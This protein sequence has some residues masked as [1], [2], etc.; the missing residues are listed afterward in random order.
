MLPGAPVAGG[1]RVAMTS[2][3]TARTDGDDGDD[4]RATRARATTGATDDADDSPAPL[5][6]Y[7]AGDVVFARGV[8]ARGREPM[9]PGV[10]V[11]VGRAPE[12]VRRDFAAACC[13]VMFYGPSGTR[14]RERDYCWAPAEG[15][16]AWARGVRRGLDAQRVAKRMRPRAFEEA[17][18]E[19]REAAAAGEDDV[20]ATESE[21]RADDRGG[22]GKGLDGDDGSREG[23]R[24]DEV[25]V[26]GLQDSFGLPCSAPAERLATRRCASCGV[27]DD[28]SLRSKNSNGLC[29]L[30][31]KLHKEGQFCPVCDRVWHWSAGDAMVGCDRCEMWIHR[32]CD[33]VAAEV[34]DREQNGEDEDIPYAC[35]VCRSKTP[36]QIAAEARLAEQA[37]VEAER[38]A[39]IRERKR[40]EKLLS[41]P[42]VGRPSKE[43]KEAKVLLRRMP[44]LDKLLKGS[45]SASVRAGTMKSPHAVSKKQN[46]VPKRPKSSWQLFAADFFQQYKDENG[47]D[48]IDFAAVYR[49]QGAAWREIDA[50][51]RER[52]EEL[53]R[54]EAERFREMITEMF[55]SGELDD[56]QRKRYD[57]ILNPDA[58]A[59]RVK[60]ERNPDASKA[61]RRSKAGDIS[62][63]RDGNEL[64]ETL[65]V[66]CNG[67][68]ADYYTRLNQ[69]MCQCSDCAGTNKYMTPTEFEKHAGMGQA[70][71]WKASL[72][73]I[74]PA[75][76][77]IGRFLDGNDF[78]A[79]RDQHT[80]DDENASLDYEIVQVSW[81]V[82]RCAVCDDERDFDFD[83]LITCE[84]CAVTVHQSCYG[85]PDIPDDTVG[86]L[87]R[88]CEHTGGAVS[89]TPLC[90][91]CP[92]AGGALKPTT[93]PSLW[94]HS[95]CCQW[96]PETT[97]LDIERME[98]IDNIANIQKERWSLLCTVCKQRMGAKIQCCHPGCYIAYHP[99]C[100]RA[101]GLYMDANDDGDD[102][103]SPLQL[104]SYCHRH[105]RV[106]VERAQIYAGTEG[107]K[108]GQEGRLLECGANKERKRTKAEM[109]AETEER[110]RREA[111]A[112]LADEPELSSDSETD[113]MNCA[114]FR[115]YEQLGHPRTEADIKDEN[116]EN[117]D[118]PGSGTKKYR[119]RKRVLHAD[120]ED[121]DENDD[122]DEDD[123]DDDDMTERADTDMV[124]TKDDVIAHQRVDTMETTEDLLQDD[125]DDDDA[126]LSTDLDVE[127][128][129]D[130]TD[131][132]DDDNAE[133]GKTDAED[134]VEDADA[135]LDP[136]TTFPESKRRKTVSERSESSPQSATLALQAKLPEAKY[137]ALPG[138]LPVPEGNVPRPDIPEVNIY[139][140]TFRGIFRPADT[141]IKCLCGRCR[142]EAEAT[143]SD[144]TT[145][146]EANRWE[147]HAGMKHTKKWKTSIRV[148]VDD[149]GGE[150][151]FGD[152][153]TDHNIVVLANTGKTAKVASM[154][155]KPKA[156]R[157]KA[158]RTH[159]LLGL[160]LGTF[161]DDKLEDKSGEETRARALVGRRVQ[162]DT[163]TILAPDW[164]DGTMIDVTITRTGIR[165]K[166]IFDDGTDLMMSFTRDAQNLKFVDGEAPDLSFLPEA[167]KLSSG[168]NTQLETQL[169]IA[170]AQFT[171]AKR[172]SNPAD[173]AKIAELGRPKK[174]REKEAWV[175][176]ENPS[177][178]KW[179]RVPQSFAEKLS[180]DDA[181]MWT[182]QKNP[183]AA[184][185]VCSV[186]Q[187]FEDDEIDRRI[188]L[189]DNAPYM[190]GSD[191]E[192]SEDEDAVRTHVPD[193]LPAMVSV[194]CKGVSGT[195]HV[196]TR[197][198]ECLCRACVDSDQGPVYHE[199][200]RF[201]AHIGVKGPK[202]WSH[203]I[204]VVLN[205]R[206]VMSLGK[207]LEVWGCEIRREK[208]VDL[209]AK[210]LGH[211][212]N[213]S[214]KQLEEIQANVYKR[215]GLN[216]NDKNA[217]VTGPPPKTGKRLYVGLT[218][219]IVRGSRGAFKRE[220]IA[221]KKYTPEEFAAVQ[222]ERKARGVN[223]ASDDKVVEQ[224][225]LTMREKLEQM[226]ASYSDRLTFAKSNIH[227]W[228]LVA[229]V[230]HK[231]GSIVTQF[232]GETCRSTVADL[233]ETFY[234]DNGVDCYLL[235]QD[236]D[237][238]VDCTF[239]GNFA[240]FTN[241]SC[242]PN[243]YSKIVKVDDANH[244]IFFARTDVRPGEELTYNYRFESEDGKVPCYCGADNCRGYLC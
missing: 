126:E 211:Q 242:N 20:G 222:A 25:G 48:N 68:A 177:C 243:M 73:M 165:Y 127:Y 84:A 57:K 70:K 168:K 109:R 58:H 195:Y 51:E 56:Q 61:S 159:A 137:P 105:C 81:S 12:A 149:N 118:A 74:E 19:A 228:G 160:G 154:S 125:D 88:S 244:I 98:P 34:L 65:A 151:A 90:C 97:V 78:N 119:V 142:R 233:R 42:R 178:G 194:V 163:G 39:Q 123:D 3:S 7:V 55:E 60:T 121:E 52:Y 223:G 138:G 64:P 184:F 80:E 67:V 93:I 185:S 112:T 72:R 221:S 170:N 8:G 214:R 171:S 143:N 9:W 94:A 139:C 234:E 86:W 32:E 161:E 210:S 36:E 107:L 54:D 46:T 5:A 38:K 92:V 63:L 111:S 108:I 134:A 117:P 207:W 62:K 53:A 200:S 115:R 103:E 89:E 129:A 113:F 189:G 44:T 219:Y 141:L 23:E 181:D 231:A 37:R 136:S 100:A 162:I 174:P 75:K 201:E 148:V 27:T 11:D 43:M 150:Q 131:D 33:A 66:I 167:A 146:W 87:C 116:E 15:L 235:K 124:H 157:P 96:I 132:D 145:L 16:M 218:P 212:R 199:R 169:A 83:Q 99:L 140:K 182:C 22:D 152:W 47:E 1:A 238:V 102:D 69:V 232:K 79:R 77:P 193:D 26:L 82:D 166:V 202:K 41:K 135:K 229:K 29:A 204:R 164:K 186:P 158:S 236:D 10:I 144:A 153:L 220:L 59:A 2:T 49:E 104:L 114:K 208:T 217:K 133:G 91:L 226:T 172:P 227:G 176:C 85:V 216:K 209:S 40:L 237:T 183:E 173:R 215:L 230:F 128:D 240:R 180:A 17:C 31:R 224:H 14:G 110:E 130:P 45:S 120:D 28:E 147:Q 13:C 76:M 30:C 213:L 205:N 71:K 192:E 196:Q 24:E 95:A 191:D 4:G 175:Q 106:D 203:H 179:R 18:E 35:P 50:S 239:Q 122:D 155:A 156:Q 190:E 197:R 188:A 21:G 101:T 241:H 6:S 198:I 187:E 206:T 225:G